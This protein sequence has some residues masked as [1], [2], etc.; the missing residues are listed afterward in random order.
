[1]PP[2]PGLAAAGA[3]DR[4]RRQG[5]FQVR[6]KIGAERGCLPGRSETRRCAARHL[7]LEIL[8][9]PG[10]SHLLELH[11]GR[12]GGDRSLDLDAHPER[13][14]GGLDGLDLFPGCRHARSGHE[15]LRLLEKRELRNPRAVFRTKERVGFV[16]LPGPPVGP[17]GI[18]QR[19][20][21]GGRGHALGPQSDA[22]APGHVFDDFRCQEPVF[23]KFLDAA[24]EGQFAPIARAGLDADEV[25]IDDVRGGGVAPDAPLHAFIA[26][27]LEQIHLDAAQP[28][29]IQLVH[30][31]PGGDFLEIPGGQ[32]G[33]V[34]LEFVQAA[35]EQILTQ[36]AQVVE[37]QGLIEPAFDEQGQIG[38]HQGGG[39]GLGRFR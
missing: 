37:S 35:F 29:G 13:G 20:H 10:L 32:F 39:A 22:A 34:D 25:A 3:P 21:F 1:M 26:A 19:P 6:L 14:G 12:L 16:Q 7:E 33:I 4:R 31:E 23:A 30:L 28:V 8:D 2:A 15:I 17:E 24:Q 5:G 11:D 9:D 27:F 18:H 36:A 38:L